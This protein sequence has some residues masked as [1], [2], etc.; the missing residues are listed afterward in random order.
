MERAA[1]KEWKHFEKHVGLSSC[2]NR[3]ANFSSAT[4]HYITLHSAIFIVNT[5]QYYS[6]VFNTN[7]EQVMS[8][9]FKSTFTELKTLY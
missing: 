4:L 3:I 9:E 8:A 2:L 5:E 6:G 7:F 1:L